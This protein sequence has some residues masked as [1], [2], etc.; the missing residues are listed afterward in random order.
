MEKQ[1]QSLLVVIRQPRNMLIL[2]FL[3]GML[4]NGVIYVYRVMPTTLPK[5]NLAMEFNKLDKQRLALEKKPLP[6]K[7]SDKD[8]EAL[9]QQVPIATQSAEFL[10]YLK[11]IELKT[12]VEIDSI[13]DGSSAKKEE[14]GALINSDGKANIPSA[15]YNSNKAANPASSANAS[16]SPKPVG[17]T[18]VVPFVEETMEITVKGSYLQLVDFI[19][20]LNYLPRLVKI[21]AWKFSGSSS[22]GSQS[23]TT[24]NLANDLL[25]LAPKQQQDI[26]SSVTKVM[27]ITITLFSAKQFIG[28]FP[29]LP[30]ISIM[31]EPERRLDP[32]ISD[33]NFNKILETVPNGKR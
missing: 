32:T 18:T 21:K 31:E 4:I 3:L 17:V 24:N 12:G 6:P 5:L 28:K 20:K 9:V 7:I 33:D 27:D 14:A 15:N 19:D 10:I 1:L 13:S 23:T 8:V 26:K 11:E 16:P 30:P 25:S 22:V 29:D 2:I